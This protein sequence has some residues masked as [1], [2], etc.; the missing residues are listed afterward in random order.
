MQGIMAHGELLS[1]INRQSPIDN[2]LRKH[3]FK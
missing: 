3:M 1:C 2:K